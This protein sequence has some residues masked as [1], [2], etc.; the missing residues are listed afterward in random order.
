MRNFLTLFE[1]IDQTQS[2]N[3][4]VLHMQNYFLK[5]EDQDAAWA[6]FFLCGH[7]MKRL[8]S[9]RLLLQWCNEIVQLPSWLI[10]ESYAAVG[11]TAETISLLLPQKEKGLNP[12]HTLS[13]LMEN[14]ILPLKNLTPAL[15]KEQ[16]LALW[17]QLSTKEIFIFN[18][19]LTGSLRVGVSTLLT[20]KALSQVTDVSREILSQ[21]L[22]GSWEPTKD[23]FAGLKSKGEGDRY[24][25]P[26]PFYLA[27]PFEGDLSTLGDP[28]EWIAEWKWDGI[29]GQAVIRNGTCALWSRGNELISNQFP[30]LIEAFKT[31]AEGTVLDGEI[32]AFQNGHPLPFAE[33]QKRLGRKNVSKAIIEKITIVFMIYDILEFNG[34]DIRTTP[35]SSRRQIINNLQF[36]SPK[37]IH[38]KEIGQN[39]WGKMHQLRLES[40]ENSTEGLMLKRR[41]SVYGVGRQKGY[42]WKYKID[43]MNLDAVL[44]YAQAGSGRRANL[45]TDY[46]FGVWHDGELIPITKAYSGLDQNEIKELDRWIRANTVEKFGPVRQVTPFQVFEIAFEGIQLSKRHK[47]GVALRFPR[48]ARWRKDKTAEQSDTLERIKETFF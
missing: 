40:R 24:L 42:W 5:C 10:E 44:L 38:S 37:F 46:T 31:I 23:F 14:V 25:N 9:G 2:T 17:D 30:E 1:K 26:Y 29:R 11:D 12:D 27:Y 19:I 6:L 48:I 3:E 15:Q 28:S 22:M 36:S 32:L 16:I 20:L 21:R 4:K 34:E 18:K 13:D 7:R 39:D 35:L 33:L 45:F 43:A 47:S 8:I 41:D